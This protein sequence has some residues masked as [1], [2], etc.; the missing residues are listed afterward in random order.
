MKTEQVWEGK[1]DDYGNSREVDIAGCTML[2]QKIETID[3]PRSDAAARGQFALFEKKTTCNASWAKRP[4]S[5]K[6]TAAVIK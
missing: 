5:R 1:H 2:L 3:Q 4:R 6:L